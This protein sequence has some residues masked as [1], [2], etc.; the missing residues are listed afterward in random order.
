VQT[1]QF[2]PQ[3]IVDGFAKALGVM[4]SGGRQIN[5]YGVEERGGGDLAGFDTAAGEEA[6]PGGTTTVVQF[7]EF[8]YADAGAVGALLG[9]NLVPEEEE[10]IPGGEPGDDE[11][12][13][14]E[15]EDPDAGNSE[16]D[17]VAVEPPEPVLVTGNLILGTLGNDQINGSDDNNTIIGVEGIDVLSGGGGDDV[18]RS[19]FQFNTFIINFNGETV[20][21]LDTGALSSLDVVDIF[22]QFIVSVTRQ[23]GSSFDVFNPVTPGPTGFADPQLSSFADTAAGTAF[24]ISFAFP[25]TS[26]SLNIGDFG[27]DQ[28]DVV[29]LQAFDSGGNTIAGG[30]DSDTLDSINPGF[31]SIAL[32]VNVPDIAFVTVSGGTGAFPHSVFYDDFSG[33]YFYEDFAGD[34][35]SGDAGNDDL[36]GAG[37]DDLLDGGTGNDDLEGDY[38]N[39]TLFGGGNNDDLFGGSGNDTLDGGAGSD[40]LYGESGD[41][42]LLGQG[43]NDDLFGSSGNDILDGGDGDDYLDGSS[44]ND[45]LT[46]GAGRDYLRDTSGSNTLFGDGGNDWLDVRSSGQDI[47]FGGDGDDTFYGSSGGDS[48]DGGAGNDTLEGNGG[49]DVLDGGNNNESSV[50][51]P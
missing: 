10:P 16:G 12:E 21:G 45:M 13:E 2:T 49:D 8:D 29:T 20:T 22:G 14:D 43:G 6:E 7:T 41:D 24:V 38:G 5:R 4:P 27:G 39:D 3:E 25:V 44:G 36:F 1:R 18:L 34:I 42:T 48:Y 23:G 37:G 35:L 50:N 30:Q 40:D 47:A 31:D 11:E 26:F 17:I 28:D 32:N 9:I 19:E 33:N 15:V 46:G 51:N